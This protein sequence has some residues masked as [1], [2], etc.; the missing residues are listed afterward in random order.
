[1][2]NSKLVKLL[3]TFTKTEL[4]EFQK[5]VE[6]PYF[7]PGR[8]LSGLLKILKKY[9]P[10]FAGRNFTAEKISVQLGKNG[11]PAGKSLL[12]MQLSE[13]YKMAERFISLEGWKTQPGLNTY[14]FANLCKKKGLYDMAEAR[15]RKEILNSPE[16]GID[17]R[18]YQ[19]Y[20]FSR[21]ELLNLLFLKDKPVEAI[22]NLNVLSETVLHQF[23][24][25]AVRYIYNLIFFSVGHNKVMEG[26]LLLGFFRGQELSVLLKSLE[27]KND[28]YS[29]ASCVYLMFIIMQLN[30]S[31]D[32]RYFTFKETLLKNI[33][34]FS[35]YEKSF[36]LQT[37]LLRTE[38]GMSGRDHKKYTEESFEIIKYRLSKNLYKQYPDAPY[39]S[40][41]YFNPLYIAFI[42]EDFKWMKDYAARYLPE[43]PEEHRYAAGKLSEAFLKFGTGD[44]KG[45]LK[46]IS[47]I[48]GL[49]F[50]LNY[51]L[52]RL[53]LMAYYELNMTDE[54][55]YGADA[56]KA[57]LKS[58]KN[59]SDVYMQ[60]NIGFVKYFLL[61]ARCKLGEVD[62]MVENMISDIESS[63]VASKNWLLEKISEI[64]R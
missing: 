53:Q 62:I 3:K 17:W 12:K 38:Y 15:I 35:D 39:T 23:L 29:R 22:E 42:L 24:S 48:T 19:N 28:I 16:T 31:E 59:V 18:Y 10:G 25:F 7:S 21:V 5:F 45:A 58:N 47:L 20:H 33:D 56:F 32:E 9:Y 60:S 34:L 44:H 27:Q 49:P 36:F 57:Y 51:E 8:D 41:E 46:I 30:Y 64:K 6:S 43:V 63:G 54:I 52:K 50:L 11:K 4:R 14:F 55:F 13:L 37:I 26:N 40:V 1:M 61:L 2:Q